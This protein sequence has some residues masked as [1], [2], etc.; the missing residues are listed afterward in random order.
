M[1]LWNYSVNYFSH[2]L[3][4][5]SNFHAVK[6]ADD[7]L[8]E[9]A[10]WSER[11]RIVDL[12]SLIGRSFTQYCT[13]LI[14]NLDPMAYEHGLGDTE[15]YLSAD[16]NTQAYYLRKQVSFLGIN[17]LKHRIVIGKAL[18]KKIQYEEDF[19]MVLGHAVVSQIC[20]PFRTR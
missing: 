2:L 10:Q 19:I 20:S 18:L 17:S 4:L 15:F 16:E 8:S 1:F 3:F 12:D 5:V 11:G 6:A 9:E 13:E 7:A 14:N